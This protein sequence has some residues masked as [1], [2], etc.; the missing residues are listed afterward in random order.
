MVAWWSFR[1][2]PGLRE[3]ELEERLMYSWFPSLT[4]HAWGRRALVKRGFG[5]SDIQQ[6]TPYVTFT[7]DL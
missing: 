7:R 1:N 6:S 4:T 3:G 2:L 5:Y